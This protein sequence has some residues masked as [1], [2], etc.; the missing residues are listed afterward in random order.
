MCGIVPD[1]LIIHT[2]P[3][4]MCYVNCRTPAREELRRQLGNMRQ[5]LN[6]LASMKETK[7]ARKA[8][9]A[10]TRVFIES[11]EKLDFA[12]RKKDLD[13]AQK[14][15]AELKSSLATLTTTLV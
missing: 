1:H 9:K 5:D 7:D 15:Y 14:A 13:A 11:A 6:T 3:Q 2:G 12:I 8:A 4:K 10:E